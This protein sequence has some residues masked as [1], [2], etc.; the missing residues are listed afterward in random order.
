M[1]SRATARAAEA[2]PDQVAVSRCEPP[3]WG[4]GRESEDGHG[5]GSALS[6]P[7]GLA[8][9]PMTLTDSRRVLVNP[10][11]NEPAG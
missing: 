5:P 4:W 7:G 10:V 6:G 3:E 1:P 11:Y 2:S 9:A 8:P